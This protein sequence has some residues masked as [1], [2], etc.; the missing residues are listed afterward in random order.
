MFGDVILLTGAL[1]ARLT[2]IGADVKTALT[3]AKVEGE[4]LTTSRYFLFWQALGDASSAEIGLA[5]ATATKVH[6]YDL[7]SL[8]ALH[9]PDVRTALEKIARYKRLCGPKDMSLELKGA[10][11]RVFTRWMHATAMPPPRLVDASL[12]SLLV[13][14]QRGSG[15]Q[16]SPRRVELSRP[17][18]D[19][20]MLQRFFG[21]PLRFRAVHDALV[22]D[23]AVLATPFVTHHEALLSVL[24]PDLEQKLSSTSEFTETVRAVIARRMSGERPSVEKVAR[25]LALSPRT[26]QRRLGESGVSYQRLLDEVRHTTAVTLLRQDRL[27]L[28]EVAFLLGFEEF[29]SFTRAFRS[30]EGTSPARWRASLASWRDPIG[31]THVGPTSSGHEKRRL[32]GVVHHGKFSRARS[33]AG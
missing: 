23:A 10:E 1:R 29:N 28:H 5:L 6:E 20:P 11:L 13:L 27:A 4:A 31:G 3:T 14:L 22:F 18:S 8:A 25:E 21:A 30:W 2:R 24:V 16:L 15:Q 12:A 33:R 19:A 32:E 7:P 17:K 9:S 26:L